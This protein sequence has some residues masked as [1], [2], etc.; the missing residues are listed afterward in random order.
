M[1]RMAGVPDELEGCHIALIGGYVVEGHVP[2][3]AI[4]KL[5]AERPPLKAITLPGMPFGSPG[6]AGTKQEPSTIYA[7]GREG[8]SS[9][10]MTV[11]DQRT[12]Q[13]N[14]GETDMTRILRHLLAV[15]ALLGAAA[16]VVPALA[17]NRHD[18]SGRRDIGSFEM[19]G[20]GGMSG[21]SMSRGGMAGMCGGMM[22]SMQDGRRSRPNEQWR[23]HAAAAERG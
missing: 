19:M 18:A 7:L 22:Q 9:I 11:Q 4:R 23:R 21:R 3:E 6:M 8:H 16:L 15:S 1:S 2:I 20:T 14:F 17:Q 13:P 10:Y 12:S 5:L